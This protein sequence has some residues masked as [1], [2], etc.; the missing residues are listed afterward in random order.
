MAKKEGSTKA[1]GVR[2]VSAGQ[3][4]H[5]DRRP[6][7][8]ISSGAEALLDRLQSQSFHQFTM[9]GDGICGTAAP[10]GE[11]LAFYPV[12]FAVDQRPALDGTPVA[13]F[14]VGVFGFKNEAGID[15][16]V[17]RSLV[18]KANVNRMV[19]SSKR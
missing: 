1:R 9:A 2:F 13:G 8:R 14:P 11:D 5:R 18:L 15:D 7:T 16:E 4:D 6:S 10:G 17:E 3:D 12:C 19:L